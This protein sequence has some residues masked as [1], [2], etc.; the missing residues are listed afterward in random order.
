[1]VINHWSENS[2]PGALLEEILEPHMRKPPWDSYLNSALN[3][4]VASSDDRLLFEFLEYSFLPVVALALVIQSACSLFFLFRINIIFVMG[5]PC[6]SLFGIEVE[7]HMDAS[8]KPSV[9]ILI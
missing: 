9:F 1:M 5:S 6:V 2:L 3:E 8:F 7:M 4:V